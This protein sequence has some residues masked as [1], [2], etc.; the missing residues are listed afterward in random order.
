MEAQ[1]KEELKKRLEKFSVSHP[2]VKCIK[3]L[4]AGQIG[5][6]KSSFI[7][8]VNSTFQGRIT[9][10]AVVD[11]SGVC[12]HSFTQQLKAHQVRSVKGDLPFY[13]TDIM[14]LEPEALAGSQPEDVIKTIY[15]HVKDEYKFKPEDP[16]NDKSQDYISDPSL[17]DKA[18]CMVYVVAAD[19]VQYM[20]EQLNEKLKIIRHRIRDS[21]IPQVIIMTKVDEVCP[22]V[23]EDIRKIYISKKIKEKMQLCSDNIGVPM[24]SIFPVKNYCD[25]INTD[26]NVD[27]LILKAFDQIVN[28]ANDRLRES[29]SK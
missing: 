18:F 21:R 6:G 27:V 7:N 24:C 14:G 13:L 19:T 28:L 4:V 9:S 8:S 1:Q 20:N 11:S 23:K 29:A 26:D 10:A 25:E 15:G 22:L 16:I 3:I 17:S 12:S 2:N 5:A